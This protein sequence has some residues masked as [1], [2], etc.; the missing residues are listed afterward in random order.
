M[1]HRPLT[2]PF[3]WKGAELARDGRWSIDLGPEA[4]RAIVDATATARAAGV[5][6]DTVT[7]QAFPL[8]SLDGLLARVRD[9]IE[10][11]CGMVRLRG[12][13]V[14]R[15]GAD[16]GLAWMGFTAHL[17]TAV[18]QNPAGQRL[19]E[20]RDEGAGVGERYGQMRVGGEGEVFLSSRARTAS[21]AGLR[22]HT[23]RCDIVG[24]LCT[25]R[26]RSGGESRVASSV[27]VHNAMLARRPDL[28]ALLYQDIPRSRLGEEDDV[29]REWYP[30]P[31]WGIRDGK[32][33]SHYSRTYVEAAQLLPDVP[34]LGPAHWE[35]L[36]MLAALADEL[37]IEMTL[38]VGD[39]QLL[40]NHV[41]YHSRAAFENDPAAGLVRCLLRVWLCA[42]HRALPVGHE[43]LWRE[44]EAGRLRG[45][46]ATAT[47]A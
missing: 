1:Q 4:A 12:F 10:D 27:A 8:T 34:R 3:A 43:V 30:L 7:A 2:G 42:P 20:I 36:D 28:A 26:A 13:P 25:G 17:G 24:L 29:G 31:I 33:T 38:E 45:G 6:T 32:F 39:V 14:D 15:L 46:I 41:I 23:D 44:I 47:T 35:A 22:Y 19:R 16:A 21:T 9:E 11:G 40:N 37:A 5:S 18:A